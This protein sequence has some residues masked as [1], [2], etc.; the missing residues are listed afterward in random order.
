MEKILG[1]D[2]GTNSLGWSIIE[3]ND[4]EL[5]FILR[6]QKILD[7]RGKNFHSTP[8]KTKPHPLFSSFIKEKS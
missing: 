7:L 1:L 3:F 4:E 8:F 6:Y 2:A 5:W